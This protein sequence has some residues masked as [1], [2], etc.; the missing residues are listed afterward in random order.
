MYKNFILDSQQ[1]IKVSEP[2]GS[3]HSHA[4]FLHAHKCPSL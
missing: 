4:L 3:K 2:N 1:K